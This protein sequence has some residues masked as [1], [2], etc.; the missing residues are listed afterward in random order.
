M[1]KWFK[2][3]YGSQFGGIRC[4][5]ILSGDGQN[6][7]RRCPLMIAGVMQKVKEQLVENGFDLSGVE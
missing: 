5:E 3:T 1:V 2:E 7:A 6:L 4:E